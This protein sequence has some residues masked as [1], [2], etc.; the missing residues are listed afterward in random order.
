MEKVRTCTH[1]TCDGP[2]RRPVK[3][4][5]KRKPIQKVSGK[6]AK[7]DRKYSVLRKEFLKANPEC[8]ARLK[9]CRGEATDVHHRAGRIGENLLDTE[10][11]LAGCPKDGIVLDPFMGA[12]TTALVAKSHGRNYIGFELNPE[13]IQM[14]EKRL[15]QKFGMFYQVA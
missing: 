10:T 1:A 12:G 15:K 14:A 2:C 8:E 13:Y 3:P 9:N 4:K 7:D 5:P 11:W 6:R